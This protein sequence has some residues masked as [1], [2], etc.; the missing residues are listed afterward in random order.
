MGYG[1]KPINYGGRLS[2]TGI[3]AQI[4]TPSRQLKKL[5]QPVFEGFRS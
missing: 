5:L 1:K 2:S 3:L 4:Y